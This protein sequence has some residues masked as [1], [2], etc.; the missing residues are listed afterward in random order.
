MAV[1][2]AAL[3]AWLLWPSRNVHGN[4][5]LEELL[6]SCSLGA[7]A[8]VK[9]YRGNAGA[10]VAY[11]YSVTAQGSHRGAERQVL[12]SYSAPAFQSLRCQDERVVV[13]SDRD[14]ITLSLSEL[15]ALRQE[16]RAFWRGHVETGTPRPA[17]TPARVVAAV[18]A[19]VSLALLLLAFR[20]KSG[21]GQNAA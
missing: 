20:V 2:L 18:S 11:W 13:A 15:P 8:L 3:S 10:T 5:A 1:A 17:V 9:L 6:D 21:L 7:K 19:G 14:S 4:P 16:P 12:F